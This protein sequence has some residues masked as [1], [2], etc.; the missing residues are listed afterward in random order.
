MTGAV[1]VPPVKVTTA[2]SLTL[3]AGAV[4][5]DPDT[6]H[7]LWLHLNE[8]GNATHFQD[9]AQSSGGPHDATC[10][11]AACPSTSNGYLGFD[12][13][14]VLTVADHP[15]LRPDRLTASMWIKRNARNQQTFMQKGSTGFQIGIDD[16]PLSTIY[17][18]DCT[19]SVTA[20]RDSFS[21]I[22]AG[23]TWRLP[24]MAGT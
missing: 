7:V 11:G 2:T 22:P 8:S 24:T 20:R 19:T 1:A 12:G 21:T 10:S 14:D 4:I 13:N 3:R 15:E 23:T 9:D 16:W 17:L 5:Q 18:D 6:G